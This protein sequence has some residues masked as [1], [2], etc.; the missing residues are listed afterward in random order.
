MK[1]RIENGFTLIELMI[2]VTIV[3]ILAAVA[4]PA[5]QDY[6]I[7]AKVADGIVLGSAL[8][9]V[10]ADNAANATADAAGGL[11]S[12]MTTG[13][14]TVPTVCAVAGVCVLTNPTRNVASIAGTTSTGNIAIAF[15]TAIAPAAFNLL[16]LAPTSNAAALAVAA[17]PPNTVTWTCYSNGKASVGGVANNATL[18]PKFAP[19][20]CR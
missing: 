4:M 15:T 10:V 16:Q 8:K 9:I 6:T 17:P 13:T 18:L 12:G 20:E 14:T 2:I 11:F 1:R 7:R 3:G 5:Y 19:A